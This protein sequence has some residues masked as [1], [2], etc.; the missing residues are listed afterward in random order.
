MACSSARRKSS[1][2]C[3]GGMKLQKKK[4]GIPSFNRFICYTFLILKK[5]FFFFLMCFF[6][7]FISSFFFSQSLK[8]HFGVSSD[9]AEEPLDNS[10]TSTKA[11]V[12]EKLLKGLVIMFKRH[13]DYAL[14][15]RFL[16]EFLVFFWGEETFSL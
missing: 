5:R 3:M 16:H 14:E 12:N 11:P 9:L 2:K 1:K 10:I 8:H 13:R 7:K 6:L 15:V 4:K